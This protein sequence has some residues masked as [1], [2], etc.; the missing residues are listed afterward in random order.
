[1]NPGHRKKRNET[2]ESVVADSPRRDFWV[3]LFALLVTQVPFFGQAFAIDDGHFIDQALQILRNPS[4]PYGFFIHLQA[5]LPFYTYFANPPLQA[6]A[7]ALAIGALGLSEI[8]LHLACLPFSALAVYAM[9]T[10][11]RQLGGHGLFAALL[12]LSTPAFLLS[13]HSVMAD[14]PAM[15][16]S[17]LAI[18][19][20]LRGVEENRA[21]PLVA[22]GVAAG[23][24]ALFKYSGLSLLPLLGLYPLLRPRTRALHFVPVGVAAAV[25]GTWIVIDFSLSGEIHVAAA[26]LRE[27]LEPSTGT[28]GLQFVGNLMGLG[29]ATIFPP[30]LLAWSIAAARSTH[31]STGLAVGLVAAAAAGLLLVVMTTGGPLLAPGTASQLQYDVENATLGALFLAAGS[32]ALVFVAARGIYAVR[33]L[34]RPRLAGEEKPSLDPAAAVLLACWFLGLVAMNSLLV[35]ATPKYLLP[36]LAPLILLLIHPGGASPGRIWTAPIGRTGIVATTLVLALAL[37]WTAH[38]QS[39]FHK[40]AITDW[41]PA[42]SPDTDRWFSAHWTIRHYAEQNGYRPLFTRPP[43][44][45]L[46]ASGDLFFFIP[47]AVSHP[48][49]KAQSTRL[50]EI[51]RREV[52]SPLRLHLANSRIGAGYWAHVLGLMP[53]VVSREPLAS[54]V[55]YRFDEEP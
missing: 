51:E 14:V 48:I 32:A 13:S 27:T 12:M 6:Y 35:F 45:P 54:L 52:A 23:I 20:L 41:I 53:Y 49:P 36:G 30:L 39:G 8:A 26:L 24:A 55:I 17:L 5:P 42:V 16:F 2:G 38:V 11:A 4:D 10:L 15:A 44:G 28:A 3:L 18:A 21:G 25:F 40:R 43:P 46:P 50:R 9:Y 22:A 1:M 31:R 34:S 37:A 47:N 33:M 19:L 7:L 29:A